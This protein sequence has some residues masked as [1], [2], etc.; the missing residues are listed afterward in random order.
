MAWITHIPE[1]VYGVTLKDSIAFGSE[2]MDI[3]IEELNEKSGNKIS[4]KKEFLKDKCL[5]LLKQN[6]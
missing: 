2:E 1:I 5:D 3:G 4:I 6:I